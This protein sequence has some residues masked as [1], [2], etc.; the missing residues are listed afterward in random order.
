MTT[1]CAILSVMISQAQT[2]EAL[3]DGGFEAGP[4]NPAWTQF[5]SNFSTPICDATCNANYTAN[6]GAWYAWFGGIDT[7]EEIGTLAQ[8]FT[9]PTTASNVNLS[10]WL[11][12]PAAAANND[13]FGVEID[14]VDMFTASGADTT[15]YGS[16]YSEVSIN[17]DNYADGSPHD[18]VLWGY[19]QA[20]APGNLTNFMV[21][22][23][24]IAYSLGAGIVQD[25]LSDGIRIQPIPANDELQVVI[26]I[27][28]H[29]TLSVEL[30]SISGQILREATVPAGKTGM[31]TIPVSELAQGSYLLRF[32][33]GE[34]VLTKAVAIHR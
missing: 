11:W 2:G 25:L 5:S 1:L 15:T 33:D 20:N 3:T 7:V 12:I 10:F 9:V 23:I 16:L 31:L 6:T 27:A 26:G 28:R 30:L 22:D 8:S 4:P 18:L 32:N 13:S 17:I 14:N 19:H 21:D 24:S 34:S 29:Q